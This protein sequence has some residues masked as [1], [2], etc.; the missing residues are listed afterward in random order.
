MNKNWKRQMTCNFLWLTEISINNMLIGHQ[1]AIWWPH[2]WHDCIWVIF[3]LCYTN[4]KKKLCHT[5]AVTLHGT[6]HDYTPSSFAHLELQKRVLSASQ[7]QLY[8][9]A[10]HCFQQTLCSLVV[11]NSEFVT[12]SLHSMF[13]VS[14]VVLFSFHMA[15]ATWNT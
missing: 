7:G 3:L 8:C 13:W 5:C 11:C 6:I 2:K 9:S 15:G 12:V 14:P 10:V 4:H 1:Q